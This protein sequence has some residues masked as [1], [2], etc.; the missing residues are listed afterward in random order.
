MEHPP[1]SSLGGKK[2]DK[3]EDTPQNLVAV[4]NS[5]R[6]KLETHLRSDGGQLSSLA[7]NASG[8]NISNQNNVDNNSEYL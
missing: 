1:N 2:A 3:A 5:L 7:N 8:Y 6:Q 4:I